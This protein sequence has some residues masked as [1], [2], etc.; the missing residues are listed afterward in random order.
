[1][2]AQEREIESLKAKRNAIQETIESTLATNKKSEA[3]NERDVLNELRMK[4]GILINEKKQ[5]REKLNAMKGQTD[6]LLTESKG[7]KRAVKYSSL[8]EIEAE[9][10]RLKQKQETTSM[11]LQD[12]KRLIKEL[13]ALEASKSTVV[14]ISEKEGQIANS[15]EQ[16]N[17]IMAQLKEKDK[18][19][20]EVQ[21]IIDV[22]QETVKSLS[23][24]DTSNRDTL[25]KLFTE[26]DEIRDAITAKIKEKNELRNDF[27]KKNDEFYNYQRAVKAQKQLK[28]E[29]EK[30]RRDEEKAAQDKKREEE[31]LKKIPYEEEQLLCD[32]LAK[33]LTITYLETGETK[34]NTEKKDDTVPVS[35]DP[36]AN[37]KPVSKKSDDVFFESGGAKKKKGKKRQQDKK[38]DA[39]AKFVL[40]MDTFEQFGLIGLVPPTSLAE[41]PNSVEELKA[42]KIWYSQQERGSVKT[43]KEIRKENQAAAA[44]I[45]QGPKP[46]SEK[47]A[48]GKKKGAAFALSTDDFVP[49]GGPNSGSSAPLKSSWG[50]AKE[51][52]A[53]PETA[54]LE[55]NGEE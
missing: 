27:R 51:P 14:S 54:P 26:R 16:R 38:P 19:I 43:A 20:D 24:K 53:E 8:T 6:K 4:K 3:S 17:V 40:N 28:W 37:A 44:S 48:N 47:A 39:K 9:I 35:D 30:A 31:E 25:T 2:E 12:E 1:M 32:Y 45:K 46:A 7:A 52:D 21:K 23:D 34:E 10:K 50:A 36:F 33:Y 29:E 49:L 18:E 11:S 13:E 42:R 41:V 5:I 15:K 22:K 55:E